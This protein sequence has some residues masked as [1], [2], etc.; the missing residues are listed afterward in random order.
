MLGGRP[1]WVGVVRM[2]VE[3][4]RDP[5][6]AHAAITCLA[7][8]VGVVV[9]VKGDPVMAAVMLLGAAA[10]VIWGLLSLARRRARKRVDET[11]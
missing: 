11:S 1:I 2:V 4:R 10:N 7:I 3:P 9:W 6:W 5:W 8:A